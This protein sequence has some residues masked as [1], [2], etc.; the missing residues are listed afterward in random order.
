MVPEEREIV[1]SITY[2]FATE[3][4]DEAARQALTAELDNVRQRA[5]RSEA[6]WEALASRAAKSEKLRADEASR[7]ADTSAETRHENIY[8]KNGPL[9]PQDPR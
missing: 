1:M 2:E 6:A 5:L 4:A 8:Q 7:K 9:G 3:R